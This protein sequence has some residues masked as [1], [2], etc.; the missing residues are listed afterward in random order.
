MEKISLNGTNNSELGYYLAGLI[1]GDGNILTS[2][3]FKSTN[4]RIYN[5]AIAISFH[6]NEMACFEHIKQIL[7][8]GGLYPDKGSNAFRFR[9]NKTYE[10][11]QLIQL[12]NGKFRTSYFVLRTSYF[13]SA[14]AAEKHGRFSMVFLG[15]Q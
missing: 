3:T 7:D 15:R 11:I 10:L 6:K 12:I 9:I 5:P 8:N 4:G 14:E 1:E 13:L 2:K